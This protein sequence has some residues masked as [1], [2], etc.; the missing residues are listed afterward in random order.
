MFVPGELVVI[1]RLG[2]GKLAGT[3]K[4]GLHKGAWIG[5]GIVLGTES[6]EHEGVVFP[7]DVIWV[8]INDRLWR[9]APEQLRRASE[10]EHAEQTLNQVGLGLL[11]TF[12]GI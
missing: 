9:C 1:W 2:T 4:T 12:P 5:P 3:K 7:T 10:R 11:K 8:V 6:R